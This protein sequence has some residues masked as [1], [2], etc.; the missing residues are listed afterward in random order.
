[1]KMCL[2]FLNDIESVSTFSIRSELLIL[3]FFLILLPLNT[4]AQ[5]QEFVPLE[6]TKGKDVIW[7]P[8]HQLLIDAMLDMAEVGP[9]D[10]FFDLGSGDGRLVIEA[11]KRGA[12]A[13]G[14]EYEAELVEFS[15]KV[16]EQQ[17]VSEKAVFYKADL[18]EADFSKATVISLFLTAELNLKLRPL[19]L[20]LPPGTRIISNSFDM[21]DW[22]PNKQITV[23]YMEQITNEIS[24]TS[25]L[26]TVQAFFWIVPDNSELNNRKDIENS[27]KN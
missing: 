18:F 12:F 24:T 26:K 4:I 25:Q 13:T 11:A 3:S 19:L 17:G 5:N 9:K 27:N 22:I 7:L 21:G 1:M 20:A 10:I 14:I 16:A 15:K 23:E 2:R 8:T 6:G